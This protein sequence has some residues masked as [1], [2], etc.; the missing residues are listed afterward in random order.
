MS[1][2]GTFDREL[3]TGLQ[4]SGRFTFGHGRLRG[5]HRVGQEIAG[6][7]DENSNSITDCEELFLLL[8]K[9]LE[10]DCAYLSSVHEMEEHPC[11]GTIVSM[12]SVMIPLILKALEDEPRS[13][14]FSA[15]Q[16]ITGKNVIKSENRGYVEKMARDWFEWAE[17]EGVRW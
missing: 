2:V 7:Y 14:W 5:L 16:A 13:W 11:F 1:S 12:G 6:T 9:R 15:L 17:S 8:A 3:V 10:L 4:S